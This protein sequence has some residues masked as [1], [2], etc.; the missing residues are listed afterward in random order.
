MDMG[1]K[2]GLACLDEGVIHVKNDGA[3][4]EEIVAG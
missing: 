2:L 1:G 3:V 4:H